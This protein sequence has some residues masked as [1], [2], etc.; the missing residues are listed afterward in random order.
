MVF[1][2]FIYKVYTYFINKNYSESD[3]DDDDER[4]LLLFLDLD[5]FF[6]SLSL[7][8]CFDFDVLLD[9]LF[10]SLFSGLLSW[11]LFSSFTSTGFEL[12]ISGSVLVAQ[13]L[14]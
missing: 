13:I 2:Y 7:F 9:C 14:F 6:F 12:P 11:S 4:L 3:V 10:L 5:F 1:A 8:L